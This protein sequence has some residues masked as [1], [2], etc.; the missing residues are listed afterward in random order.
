MN[1]IL[2]FLDQILSSNIVRDITIY[3]ILSTVLKYIFVLIIYRF[4]L[5]IV[6]MIYLDIHSISSKDV[7]E[8][9]FLRLINRKEEFDFQI[10]DI[11]PIESSLSIGRSRGNEIILEDQFISKQHAQI[12]KKGDKFIIEDLNSANGT[13]LNGYR[14]DKP[15]FMEDKDIVSFGDI[16][17]L[18]VKGEKKYE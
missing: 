18:F 9:A 6:R 12:S 11:Y 14:I 17:F 13:Y 3:D 16:E 5:N 1:Q 7:L 15:E 4:I 10:K 2:M 8:G